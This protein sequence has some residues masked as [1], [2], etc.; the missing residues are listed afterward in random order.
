MVHVWHL[1]DPDLTEARQG[2]EEIGKFLESH[3][4]SRLLK[5]FPPMSTSPILQSL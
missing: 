4:P 5:Y 2:F 1:F 3:A